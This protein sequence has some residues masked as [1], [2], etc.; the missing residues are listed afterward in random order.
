M[1]QSAEVPPGRDGAIGRKHGVKVNHVLIDYENVQ[2]DVAVA[3]A[4][5][6][7]KVW[8][9]VGAQQSKVKFD[10]VD[11][12]QSKGD[13]AKVIRI[14]S[15]GRNALDFHISYYL[16][17]LARDCPDDYFHVIGNDTGLDPLLSHLNEQGIRAARWASVADIPIVKASAECPDEEK[18][19]RI[20]EFL[21][22]RGPQRPASWKTLV[23]T[24]CALFQPKLG[25]PEAGRL[26]AHLEATGTFVRDGSHI[27]YGLPD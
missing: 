8:V 13:A 20:L 10:L 14:T 9:F 6:L 3:L 17:R 22:R 26:L 11:L 18:L 24:T 2:P 5:P 23:G 16:G 19:S 27:R 15:T 1:D 25:E 21:L 4:E 7:F 12:V